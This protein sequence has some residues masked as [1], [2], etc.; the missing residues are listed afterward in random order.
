MLK[1][2]RVGMPHLVFLKGFLCP[3]KSC[4]SWHIQYQGCSCCRNPYW[5]CLFLLLAINL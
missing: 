2:F 4:V 3:A 1:R 5:L